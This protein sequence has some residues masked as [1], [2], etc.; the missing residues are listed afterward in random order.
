MKRLACGV[1]IAAT[2]L[3]ASVAGLALAD[4]TVGDALIARRVFSLVPTPANEADSITGLKIIVPEAFTEPGRVIEWGFFSSNRRS[5]AGITPLIFEREA[6]SSTF[7]IVGIGTNQTHTG[8]TTD[9]AVYFE[10]GL[11]TGSDEVGP[12]R[13]FGIHQGYAG[14]YD[15]G[16]VYLGGATNA[17]NVVDYDPNAAIPPESG[18]LYHTLG[19]TTVSNPVPLLGLKVAF[20]PFVEPR[21]Y[22]L[23]AVAVPIPEPSIAWLVG[24]GLG[25]LM[26]RHLRRPARF[27]GL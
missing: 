1:L 26:L 4:E 2:C 15:A 18:Y 19:G 9:K 25:A 6:G 14:N 7:T 11:V 3:S 17:S 10:F 8:A 22:S 12:G 21:I 5:F 20:A 23:T 13:Y 16:G 24:A 27:M